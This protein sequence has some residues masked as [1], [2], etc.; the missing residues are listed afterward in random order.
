MMGKII[1]HTSSKKAIIVNIIIMIGTALISIYN[2][3]NAT[4]GPISH[5]TA[6]IWGLQ[7]GIVNT[8]LF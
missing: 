5:I 7:D 4:F 2:I 8:H 6:F 3:E 1:D